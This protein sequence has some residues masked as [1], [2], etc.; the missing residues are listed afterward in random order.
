MATFRNRS[1]DAHWVGLGLPTPSLVEPDE[2]VVV[3][4]VACDCTFG[5]L[6]VD[7][8]TQEP[9]IVERGPHTLADH[10]DLNDNF[11]RVDSTPPSAPVDPPVE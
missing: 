3:P 2:T 8:E 4:D 11:V 10:Y 5:E 6:G 7:E 9:A 1:D